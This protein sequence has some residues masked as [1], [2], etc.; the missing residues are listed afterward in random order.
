[1]GRKNKG[2]LSTGQNYGNKGATSRDENKLSELT[3]VLLKSECVLLEVLH[4][5]S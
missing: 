3:D 1:M 5:F 2:G 4:H